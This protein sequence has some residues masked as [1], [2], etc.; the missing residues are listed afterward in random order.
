MFRIVNVVK[1]FSD[2]ANSTVIG[3]DRLVDSVAGKAGSIAVQAL[4]ELPTNESNDRFGMIRLR[5]LES[6]KLRLNVTQ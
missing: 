6:L 1:Y 5:L 2:T 4:A 3:D